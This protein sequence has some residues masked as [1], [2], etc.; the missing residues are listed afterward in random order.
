MSFRPAPA[1]LRIEETIIG[2]ILGKIYSP[3][4]KLPSV[5]QLSEQ[6]NVSVGTVKSA[7]NKLCSAGF[8]YS[9]QGKG[10]FVI[11]AQSKNEH[12]EYYH[13][14]GGFL[15]GAVPLSVFLHSVEEAS[16]PECA[17]A[18]FAEKD[19]RCFRV[20][21]FYAANEQPVLFTMSFISQSVCP[22]FASLTRADLEHDAFYRLLEER[23]FIRMVHSEEIMQAVLAD[24]AIARTLN[25]EL[26]APLLLIRMAGYTTDM[27]PFEYRESYVRTDTYGLTRVH[28]FHRK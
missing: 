15:A 3:G 25:C 19:Q 4:D 16:L 12:A 27:R 24:A 5:K 7:L 20:S 14:S 17:Q 28:S 13:M 9:M 6:F 18:L 2:R 11:R 26:N 8:C 1:Y 22:N 23:F 21:R 10:T